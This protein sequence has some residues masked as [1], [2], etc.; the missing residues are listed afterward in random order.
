MSV[1]AWSGLQMFCI[2][3]VSQNGAI[4]KLAPDQKMAVLQRLS[5]SAIRFE[6]KELKI[7]K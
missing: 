6:I 3:P 5:N 4:A 1:S 7:C 2:F